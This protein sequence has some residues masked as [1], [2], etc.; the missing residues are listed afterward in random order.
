[1]ISLA[2]V[3]KENPDL[4]TSSQSTIQS[5]IDLK[6]GDHVVHINH[7]IGRFVKSKSYC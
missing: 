2:E 7:G 3:T 5:F 6:E 4:K 1:M